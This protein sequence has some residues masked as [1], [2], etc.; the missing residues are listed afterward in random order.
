MMNKHY[1]FHY[2]HVQKKK[3]KENVTFHWGLR[4]LEVEI[5]P[6]HYAFLFDR[7]FAIFKTSSFFP[8]FLSFLLKTLSTLNDVPAGRRTYL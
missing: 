6:I 7:L 1:L 2:T 3:K 8:R 4:F 5:Q